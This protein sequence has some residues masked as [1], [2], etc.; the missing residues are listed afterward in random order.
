M[1]C[2]I[3]A[4]HFVAGLVLSDNV[5]VRTAPILRYM[6]GW[7]LFDV[8]AYCDRKGWEMSVVK[9]PYKLCICGGRDFADRDFLF[10]KLDLLTSKIRGKRPI[11]VITGGAS[12]ADYLAGEWA[13][14]RRYSCIN[15]RA[16]WEA[17]GRAAGPIRNAEML[18]TEKPDVLIAFSGG[19]GTADCI[20]QAKGRNIPVREVRDEK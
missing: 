7:A 12:G 4:K 1:L 9:K 6:K 18:E 5:V 19:K 8:R 16:N 13:Y 15:Y 17:L 11:I 10:A 14:A 2:R 20:R 3:V